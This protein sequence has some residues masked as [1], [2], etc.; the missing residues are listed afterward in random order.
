MSSNKDQST[1][2]HSDDSKLSKGEKIKKGQKKAEKKMD[3]NEEEKA[4]HPDKRQ[5]DPK[6]HGAD[7]PIRKLAIAESLTAGKLA[8]LFGSHDMAGSFFLGNLCVY[9]IDFKSKLLGVNKKHAEEVDCVS[10]QVAAEMADGILKMFE[11]DAEVGVGVTGFAIT[12][13]VKDLEPHTYYCIKTK[14][15]DKREWK[16]EE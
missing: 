12:E 7:A 4:V 1:R 14:E 16:I 2:K 9:Q 8:D 10:P 11:P 3:F 13:G 5:Y 15:G 6:K